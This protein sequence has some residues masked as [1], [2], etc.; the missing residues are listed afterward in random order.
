MKYCSHCGA[1][2]CD[3][4]VVCTKCGCPLVAPAAGQVVQPKKVRTREEKFALTSMILGIIAV[5][6][7]ILPSGFVFVALPC[8]VLGLIFSI[9]AKKRGIK[10]HATA[11]L[12]LSIIALSLVVLLLITAI[13]IGGLFAGFIF[14]AISGAM[15][16]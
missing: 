8:G 16:Y 2:H 7:V 10:K 11:G 13:M 4:A 9:I 3:E 12:V 6:A 15:P 5:S 1:E 14:G